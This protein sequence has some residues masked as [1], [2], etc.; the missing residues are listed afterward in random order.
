MDTA[1]EAFV[2]EKIIT[3]QDML[4]EKFLKQVGGRQ[5]NLAEGFGRVL[6]R[7]FLEDLA[8]LG[9]LLLV[10]EAISLFELGM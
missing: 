6:V 9:E 1:E 2:V 7:P 3:G 8:S 10:E 5:G 4:E